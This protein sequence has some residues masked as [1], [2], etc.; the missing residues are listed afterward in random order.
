MIRRDPNGRFTLGASGGLPQLTCSTFVEAL[1]RAGGFAA[2]ED[3]RLWYVGPDSTARRLADASA[4]RKLW[5]HYVELPTLRFTFGQA[6]RLMAV[7]AES[8]A[9]ALDTLVELRLIE[10]T[11]DCQYVKSHEYDATI[12]P[13]RGERHAPEWSTTVTGQSRGS[14]SSA[15]MIFFADAGERHAGI[16]DRPE[17]KMKHPRSPSFD[18]PHA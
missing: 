13:P 5:K 14:R 1:A 7:D 3:V 2:R 16:D 18:A 15:S 8:C 10:K 11:P 17:G 6:R 12:A 4:L 9:Y